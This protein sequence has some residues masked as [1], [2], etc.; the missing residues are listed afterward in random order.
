MALVVLIENHE[1][2]DT[3]TENDM[4]RWWGHA[5]KKHSQNGEVFF[6]FGSNVRYKTREGVRRL[7]SF[8]IN[9]KVVRRPI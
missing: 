7:K 4:R 6:E 8:G 1:D 5:C 9:A 3:Y 2:F